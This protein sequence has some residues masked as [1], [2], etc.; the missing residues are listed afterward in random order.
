MIRR[1]F[2][3]VVVLS[4]L[5]VAATRA[6]AQ[7]PAPPQPRFSRQ[8]ILE[9]LQGAQVADSPELGE[10]INE[11]LSDTSVHMRMAPERVAT[12]ADSARAAAAV[13]EARAS[14]AK[15]KDVAVAEA[16]GYRKFLPRVA[17]QPIYHYNNIQNAIA[18]YSRFDAT[19]PVSL[20]YRKGPRGEL[21]L[22]GVM[23]SAPP[24]ATAEEIDGRLPLG[25]AHWHEHI[26]FCGPTLEA[27]QNGS[28]AT[29]GA[30]TAK[31]LRITSREECTAAGGRFVPRLFGWMTHA[32][33]FAG[34]DPKQI[35]GGEGKQHMH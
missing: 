32:Y 7:S 18:G 10:A 20:L 5:V 27:Y 29:D 34:D 12:A 35:W 14:L 13:L 2:P 6:H 22:V 4:C 9:L 28:A 31:W 23:Y 17:E 8:Q 24:S 30:S 19:K 25:V 33:I 21:V 3:C 11:L 26:N 16:E 1:A 15:Y